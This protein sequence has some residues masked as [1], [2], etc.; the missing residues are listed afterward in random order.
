MRGCAG[1]GRESI[2]MISPY[3]TWKSIDE[4]VAMH[5]L[6]TPIKLIKLIV[7]TT[8]LQIPDTNYAYE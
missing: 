2:K 1:A 5:M 4:P 7:S 6:F 3:H 8:L